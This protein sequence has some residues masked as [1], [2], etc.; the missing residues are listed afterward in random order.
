MGDSAD[1]V[2]NDPDQVLDFVGKR[3]VDALAISG[4][5]MTV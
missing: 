4:T 5:D 2:T 3:G 1:A